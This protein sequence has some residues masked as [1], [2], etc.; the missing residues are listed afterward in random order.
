M[1]TLRKIPKIYWLLFLT[2]L[3]GGI[4]IFYNYG[5]VTGGSDETL[6][7]NSA[8]KFFRDFSLADKYGTLLPGVIILYIPF[9]A[10][11]LATYLFLGLGNISQL[12]ELVIVDTY[13]FAPYFRLVTVIFGIIVVYIFYKIC[14]EIFKKQRPSLIASYLVATSLI[15]VQQIHLAGAWIAQTMMILISV[16]YSLILLKKQKWHILDFLISALLIVFSFEIEMVGLIAIVPFLL[17]CWQKRKD[18]KVS[19]WIINLILF[20]LLIILGVIFFAYLNPVTFRLY[21]SIFDNA[22]Q[23]G[24]SQTVYGRGLWGR[25]LDPFWILVL[26]EPLL[27]SLALL[28]MIIACKKN[29]FLWKFFGLYI[30][31]Y[32]LVLGPLLGG[33]FERRLLPIIPALA[34]FAAVFID[35]LIDR[36][37]FGRVKKIIYFSL[38]I[39]LINPVVFD[40]V[41]L[42]KGTVVETRKWINENIPANAAI[43]DE[44]RINL[45]K[46][47]EILQTVFQNYPIFFTTRDRYLLDH[48]ESDSSQKKYFLVDNDELVNLVNMVGRD[49]FQYLVF[50]YY[51]N[52]DKSDREKFLNPFLQRGKTKIYDYPANNKYPFLSYIFHLIRFNNYDNFGILALWRLPVYGPH[53]EIFKFK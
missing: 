23:L 7:I 33:V 16:Y 25:I 17:I 10:L 48:P 14:L 31:F 9:I 36:Y 5:I 19:Q 44:C 27:F 32:Y 6:V 52:Y 38:L 11:T 26:L 20:F 29:K 53:F 1:E 2:A 4:N 50:C 35:F 51:N 37:D 41:F 12:N 34:C 22:N 24:L 21:L 28:G 46:N 45:G 18:M 42:K 8:L 15:F 40:A 39:F 43:F 3:I 47:K 13:K 30:V 49:K